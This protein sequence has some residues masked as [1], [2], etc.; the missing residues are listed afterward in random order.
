MDGRQL[1]AR[2]RAERPGLCALF[3]SGYRQGAE[4]RDEDDGFIAKPFS[5]EDL[6]AAVRCVLDSAAAD[7][8]EVLRRVG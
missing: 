3:M 1:V 7:E 4:D 5:P 2:L 8:S 6:A